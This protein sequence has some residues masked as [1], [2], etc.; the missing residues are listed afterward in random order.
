MNQAWRPFLRGL[1]K[2]G[3]GDTERRVIERLAEERLFWMVENGYIHKLI[4]QRELLKERTSRA[5]R[6]AARAVR[7]TGSCYDIKNE[8]S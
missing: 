3:Y 1:K 4:E 5:I 2:L 8:G 6:R 7:M